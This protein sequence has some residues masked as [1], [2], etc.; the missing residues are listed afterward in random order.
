MNHRDERAATRGCGG[1][2]CQSA[3]DGG[4]M[5]VRNII[6]RFVSSNLVAAQPR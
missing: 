6:A 1:S 5:T 2:Q 4:L 3:C